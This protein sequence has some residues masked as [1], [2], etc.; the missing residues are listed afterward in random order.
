MTY[1]NILLA[2]IG[3]Y[4]EAALTLNAHHARSNS[5]NPDL[6]QPHQVNKA[7]LI[8]FLQCN[9]W[10]LCSQYCRHKLYASLNFFDFISILCL[11]TIKSESSYN[12]VLA[13]ILTHC[14]KI[15]K[16]LERE[17]LHGLGINSIIGG[18]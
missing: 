8:D 17:S 14:K 4:T 5:D 15:E 12:T 16:S 9:N 3:R 2:Q 11:T 1:I 10:I 18:W 7:L 13:P 6:G